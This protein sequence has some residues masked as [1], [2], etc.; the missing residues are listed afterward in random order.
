MRRSWDRAELAMRACSRAVPGDPE[1]R[2]GSWA[3]A[4]ELLLVGREQEPGPSRTEFG[5]EAV[6][7]V[8]R[9]AGRAASS[10]RRVMPAARGRCS[11]RRAPEPRP[12]EGPAGRRGLSGKTV[13]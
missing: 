10:V 12:S 7:A 9:G 11:S 3:A 5:L 1:P 2:L 4:G 8:C 6:G 13:V